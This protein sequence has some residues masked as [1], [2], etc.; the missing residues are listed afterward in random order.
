VDQNNQA[1]GQNDFDD[2]EENLQM[3]EIEDRPFNGGN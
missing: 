3:I 2:D 1:N